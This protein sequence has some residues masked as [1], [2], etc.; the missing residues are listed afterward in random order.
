MGPVKDS[1]ESK[2]DFQEQPEIAATGIDDLL[3]SSQ[4]SARQAASPSLVTLRVESAGATET[5]WSVFVIGLFSFLSYAALIVIVIIKSVY[6]DTLHI[7]RTISLEEA[8]VTVGAVCLAFLGA[9]F[10]VFISRCLCTWRHGQVWK[11]RRK[12]MALLAFALGAIQVFN[13]ICWIIPNAVIVARFPSCA[14]F[15]RSVVVTGCLRWSCWNS[16]LLVYLVMGSSLL[17]WKGPGAGFLPNLLP[18]GVGG[19]AAA[20]QRAGMPTHLIGLDAPWWHQFHK[21]P[22]WLC[23]EAAIIIQAGNKHI[24]N[25]RHSPAPDPN[26]SIPPENCPGWHDGGDQSC[27]PGAWVFATS[28]GLI[29]TSAAY[30]IFYLICMVRVYFQLNKQRFAAF[31]APNILFH[32]QLRTVFLTFKVLFISTVDKDSD[33]ILQV[34]LQEVVWTEAGMPAQ[35]EAEPKL[36]NNSL[37]CPV[38]DEDNADWITGED[39]DAEVDMTDAVTADDT[40]ASITLD[41]PYARSI[42]DSSFAE[43]STSDSLDG[44]ELGDLACLDISG[45][46]QYKRGKRKQTLEELL[47]AAMGMYNLTDVRTFWDPE[48][49]TKCVMGWSEK[50]VVLAFRGTASF[51]NAWSDLK[52]WRTVHHSGSKSRSWWHR[53]PLVHTGFYSAWVSKGLDRQVLTHLKD[54]YDTGAVQR[55]A[56]V[57]VTGHSLGG[58]LA[59]LAAHDIAVELQ[60]PHLQVY[61]IGCPYLGNHQFAA[62]YAA[63]VP[64]TWHIMNERDTVTRVGKFLF[65]FKRPGHRVIFTAMGDMLVRPSPLELKVQLQGGSKMKHHMLKSYRAA[66]VAT[67]LMQFSHRGGDQASMIKALGLANCK[68]LADDLARDG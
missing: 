9:R 33:P 57:S 38:S 23:F 16:S 41:T 6:K 13:L 68:V 18:F 37:H 17:A 39:M 53:A 62:D 21:L 47:T 65:L 31:R 28:V 67:L 48:L 8:N 14:F 58:A 66:M 56:K 45:K 7:F 30:F 60:P 51:I 11:P 52:V 64:D 43:A 4:G 42:A 63:H 10:C 20:E 32:L 1:M 61:T 5:K 29:V 3:C 46:K 26:A 50:H 44:G 35:E 2:R 24:N 59:M 40:S 34:W 19:K 36:V 12:R 27:N 25:A 22:L 49:D 55:D 15:D 54:L